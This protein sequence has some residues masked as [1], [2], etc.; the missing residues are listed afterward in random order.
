MALDQCPVPAL[1]DRQ[2]GFPVLVGGALGI[3]P[4]HRAAAVLEGLAQPG[5][6]AA[7]A[8]H[9]PPLTA[10]RVTMGAD[11]ALDGGESWE[12]PVWRCGPLRFASGAIGGG[13]LADE[14]AVQ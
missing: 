10:A 6:P 14:L 7:A 4:V 8:H 9:P 11:E 3:V 12:R 13:D 2:A 1:A 5:Q